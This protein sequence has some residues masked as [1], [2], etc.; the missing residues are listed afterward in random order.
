MLVN[1][2]VKLAVGQNCAGQTRNKTISAE[3][4]RTGCN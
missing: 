3:N 4:M 2:K 1:L